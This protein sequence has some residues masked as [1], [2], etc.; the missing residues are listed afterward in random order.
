[1]PTTNSTRSAMIHGKGNY[2][3]K[4]SKDGH[5]ISESERYM[6][7]NTRYP[8]LKLKQSGEGT[9]SQVA[10]AG[11]YTVEITHNLGYVPICFVYGEYFDTSAEAVV[12]K[13][14]R[15]NKWLYQGLQVADSYYYYADTTKLYIVLELSHITD[16]FSFDLDIQYHIFYDEDII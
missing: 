4:V 9:L 1:M 2:G 13:F 12:H 6:I 16:A 3:L 7:M 8:V 15:W 14:S 10:S 11:G 5:D